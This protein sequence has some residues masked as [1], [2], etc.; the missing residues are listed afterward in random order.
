MESS[1]FFGTTK[2]S[3]YKTRHFECIHNFVNTILK[4]MMLSYIKFAIVESISSGIQI[5]YDSS[6]T[7]NLRR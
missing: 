6:L 4:K 5:N 1:F 7:L 3:T 2:V